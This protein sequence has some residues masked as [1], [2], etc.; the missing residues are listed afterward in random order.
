MEQLQPQN[1]IYF[2]PSTLG[3][4]YLDVHG[5]DMPNDVVKYPLEDWQQLLALKSQ[6]PL[7]VAADPETGFPMLIEPP[8]LSIEQMADIEREWRNAQLS[9]TDGVVTRH[10]DEVEEGSPT[11]LTQDQYVELQAY[12]RLLRG[13]PE[14]ADF[15][16]ADS[17]PVVPIWLY[18]LTQ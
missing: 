11:T 1:M 4:Y 3:A 17:R 15:P 14:A 16:W 9:A 10:R 6:A 2:S 7:V 18:S 12:R 8:P 13:W 5:A